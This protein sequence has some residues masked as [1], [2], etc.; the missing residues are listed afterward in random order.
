MTK[1]KMSNSQRMECKNKSK[2]LY[3]VPKQNSATFTI[4]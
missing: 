4:K 1:Y 2:Q 3:T